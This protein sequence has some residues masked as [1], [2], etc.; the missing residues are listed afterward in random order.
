MKMYILMRLFFQNVYSNA[1]EMTQFGRVILSM[2]KFELKGKQSLKA[3]LFEM[4]I[5]NA[6]DQGLADLSMMGESSGQLYI[7]KVLHDVYFKLDESGVEGAAVT[8]VG[9]GVTS[10]PPALGTL[11]LNRPFAIVVR[12]ADSINPLFIGKIENPLE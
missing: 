3:P 12:R 2:P 10:D 6:F 11:N 8:T 4:G 9:V 7:T 5:R 1:V